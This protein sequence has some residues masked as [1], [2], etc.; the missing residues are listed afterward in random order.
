MTTHCVTR[1]IPCP[2]YSLGAAAVRKPSFEPLRMISQSN[3]PAGAAIASRAS[4]IGR[5]SSCANLRAFICHSRCS[6]FNAKSMVTPSWI[7]LCVG[8]REARNRFGD[9]Q[10]GCGVADFT[11]QEDQRV[12]HVFL[13]RHVAHDAH[14]AEAF[15]GT[16]GYLAHGLAR[17]DARDVM[18]R[19][20]G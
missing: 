16:L 12:A 3:V 14:R 13:H 7:E 9:E 5:I 8:A 19:Q 1:S 20:A 17:E 4:D 18:Q 10:L 15:R 6:S 11:E 2:P